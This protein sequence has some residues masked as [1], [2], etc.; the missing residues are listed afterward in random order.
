MSPSRSGCRA[1][2]TASVS[3]TLVLLSVWQTRE[4]N[5]VPAGPPSTL[6]ASARGATGEREYGVPASAAGGLVLGA[7][8]RLSESS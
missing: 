4:R 1:A 2:T 8:R 3:G 7:P 6:Y 5:F